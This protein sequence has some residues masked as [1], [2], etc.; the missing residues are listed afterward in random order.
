MQHILSFDGL[1]HP[2]TINKEW[3]LLSEKSETSQMRELYKSTIIDQSQKNQSISTWIVHPK[4]KHLNAVEIE[5]GYRGPMNLWWVHQRARDGDRLLIH[6]GVYDPPSL[7]V[8]YSIQLIGLGKKVLFK[9]SM[10]TSLVSLAMMGTGLNVKLKNISFCAISIDTEQRCCVSV[11]RKNCRLSIENCTFTKFDQAIRFAPELPGS[12]LLDV[13][14]C[15][16]VDVSTAIFMGSS[17]N[18]NVMNSLFKQCSDHAI[19]TCAGTK[20]KCNGNTFED[21]AMHPIFV[22]SMH[23]RETPVFRAVGFDPDYILRDNVIKGNNMYNEQV[24]D[25]NTVYRTHDT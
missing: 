16:F 1:Y 13:K 22:E 8:Y 11:S 14:E 20:L 5:L 7:S 17:V 23:Q 3:K 12:S 10:I 6:D 25:A 9:N 2:R 4:R 15:K 21:N 18:A 19:T 24:F